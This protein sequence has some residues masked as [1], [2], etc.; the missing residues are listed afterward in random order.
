MTEYTIVVGRNDA[1][2][3]LDCVSAST[4]EASAQKALGVQLDREGAPRAI[5][6]R[7]YWMKGLSKSMVQL[8]ETISKRTGI[9]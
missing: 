3:S 1:V 6:C 2:Q 5:A 8:Y 7:V 9:G 4:P